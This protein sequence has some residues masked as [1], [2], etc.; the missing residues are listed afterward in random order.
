MK[1]EPHFV[2]MLIVL[3]LA[4]AGLM[5]ALAGSMKKPSMGELSCGSIG[6][7]AFCRVP[8]EDINERNSLWF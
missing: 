6:E 4:E 3:S 7:N 5:A 8:H 2:L 1:G